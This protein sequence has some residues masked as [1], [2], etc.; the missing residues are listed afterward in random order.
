[1][2]ITLK[3]MKAFL[4][5]AD[6]GSF[7]RAAERLRVAQPALSQNVRE[8]EAELG[9]RLLHRT[10]RRVELTEGGREFQR[11]AAKIFE[12]LDLAVHHARDLGESRRGRITV[13]APPL[14]AAIILPQAILDFRNHHPGVQVALHDART[15]QIVEQVRAGE[16]DCGVGTFPP[17]EEGITRAVL[18]RDSLMLFC[19]YGSEFHQREELAWS[20]LKGQPLVTLTRESG[21]RL[22]VE[23]GFEA[24]ELPVKPAFEVSQ[25]TTALALVEA[26]LGVAVLPTYAWAAARYRKVVAKPLIRP[27]ISRDVA[28]I[29]ASERP[30]SPA[31]ASFSGFLRKH[32]QALVPREIVGEAAATSAV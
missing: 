18:A 19:G 13:A 24:A 2:S 28:I 25:I 1:M 29:T 27:S 21:I 14:L 30:M 20:D 3:Q 12:E 4:A 11:A 31:M 10:T 9:I 7:T 16:A 15:D 23:L 5:V 8:L 32:T 22:L 17:T 6:L 26:G